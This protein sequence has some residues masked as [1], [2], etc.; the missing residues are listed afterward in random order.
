MKGHN[1]RDIKIAK[2]AFLKSGKTYYGLR[3]N[4][5]CQRETKMHVWAL[6]GP[7]SDRS[8]ENY[9]NGDLVPVRGQELLRKLHDGAQK[10]SWILMAPTLF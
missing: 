10:G 2:L 6:T 7:V 3:K 1:E 5:S 8:T 9:R 4:C